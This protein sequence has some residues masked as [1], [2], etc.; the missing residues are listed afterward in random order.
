[1]GNQD[2]DDPDDEDTGPRHPTAAQLRRHRRAVPTGIPVL[3]DPELAPDPIPEPELVWPAVPDRVDAEVL[4]RAGRDPGE[5]AMP[6]EIS[7]IVRQIAARL[8]EEFAARGTDP[9]VTRRLDAL[10]RDFE[11]HKRFGK[12]VAGVA[13]A[14]LLAV[15]VFLYH[16][17]ADEQHVADEIKALNKEAERLQHQI[18]QIATPTTSKEPRP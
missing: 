7:A 5:P 16:R 6:A 18:D 9:G 10:E 1:V 8:R 13:G 2:R 15:G 3:D 4:R 14:A 17:G 12:W 11:P